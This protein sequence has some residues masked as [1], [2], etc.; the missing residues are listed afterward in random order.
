MKLDP[1]GTCDDPCSNVFWMLVH[2][3]ICHPL[4]VLTLYSE[5]AIRFHDWTSWKAWP[6]PSIGTTRNE[7]LS[8][9]K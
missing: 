6:D 8:N 2:D 9:E 3:G 1:N 5:W 4:L 7:R